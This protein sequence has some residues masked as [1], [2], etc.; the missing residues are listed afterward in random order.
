MK[1][2]LLIILISFWKILILFP[3]KFQYV[4]ATVIGNLINSLPLKRNKISKV[5]VIAIKRF[6]I[7]GTK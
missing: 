2:A 3:I 7:L 6:I 4:L 5:K 1:N